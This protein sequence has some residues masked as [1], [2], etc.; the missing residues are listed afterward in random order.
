VFASIS[1]T[2]HHHPGGTVQPTQ[3]AIL[4]QHWQLFTVVVI[5]QLCDLATFLMGIARVGIG[6]ESNALVRNLYVHMGAGGPVLLKVLTLGAVLPL[7]FVVAARWPSRILV[8]V[9]LAVIV[10][11]I[12]VY[13]NVSNALVI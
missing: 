11:M 8:P 6:A 5:A 3:T 9:L 7:L 10:S 4:R 2:T 12:G 13:G 1:G